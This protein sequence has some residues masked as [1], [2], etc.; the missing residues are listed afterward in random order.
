MLQ[1]YTSGMVVRQNEMT[2]QVR[3]FPL[4]SKTY[5]INFQRH[6]YIYTC[7]FITL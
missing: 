1:S 3:N 7:N 6:I 4:L 2:Q 5:L